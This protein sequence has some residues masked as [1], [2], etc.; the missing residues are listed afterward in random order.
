MGKPSPPHR[1]TVFASPWLGVYA[2][3][4]DSARHFERHSHATYGFGVM[5]RGAQHSASGR[6]AVIASAGDVMTTNPGEVHDGRPH[7]VASR[8]W[9]MI[10]VPVRFLAD[11]TGA[12][13]DVAITR[14]VMTDSGLARSTQRVVSLLERW[15]VGESSALECEEAMVAACSRLL[16]RHG[17]CR[18]PPP[19]AAAELRSVRDHVLGDLSNEPT[20]AE[21]ATTAAISRFQLLRQFRR[22]YGLTPHGLLQQ[23]RAE[24]A[25]E[26]IGRGRSLADAAA[27]SG[28][29]DQS[30]M[31]RLFTRQFGF[32]PGAWQRVAASRTSSS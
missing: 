11:V 18:V 5:E 27:A 19:V 16:E 10:H 17:T 6:G 31:T 29:S 1:C 25:R 20:L 32:T 26:L 23:E 12:P 14:P 8:C 4:T 13:Q 15:A 7:A 21:L 9:R 3:V 30:H 2:T 22:A 28:F 24:H